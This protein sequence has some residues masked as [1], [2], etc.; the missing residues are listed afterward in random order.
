MPRRTRWSGLTGRKEKETILREVGRWVAKHGGDSLTFARLRSDLDLSAARVARHWRSMFDLRSE[1]GL[2]RHGRRRSHISDE[3]LLEALHD[4]AGRLGR[5]PTRA[6][7]DADSPFSSRTYGVRFGGVEGVRAAYRKWLS[8]GGHVV[9]DDLEDP[10]GPR[11]DDVL[12]AWRNFRV[13][14]VV[15]TTQYRDGEMHRNFT[16]DFVVCVEHDWPGCPL[17]VVTLTELGWRF[18]RRGREN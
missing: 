15:R 4:L 5:F 6:E 13:G 16:H 10:S 2:P 7:I 8:G 11:L 3:E 1:L 17:P 12:E 9:P 18:D 14:F